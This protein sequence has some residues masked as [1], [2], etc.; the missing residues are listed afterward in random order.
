MYVTSFRIMRAQIRYKQLDS[1]T[2]SHRLGMMDSR[3]QLVYAQR[4][5]SNLKS[6]GMQVFDADN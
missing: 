4:K 1:A 6:K 2:P 5:V 3:A